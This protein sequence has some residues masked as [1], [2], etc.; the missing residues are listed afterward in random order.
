VDAP[1]S[2]APERKPLPLSEPRRTDAL[3]QRSFI[4]PFAADTARKGTPR[5]EVSP[6]E[7]GPVPVRQGPSPAASTPVIMGAAAPAMAPQTS[8]ATANAENV[9]LAVLNALSS[10]GQTLLVSMLELGEW[11]IQGGELTIKV[12]ASTSL[13][14]MSVGADA[15]RIMVAAASGA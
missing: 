13:I 4:S 12:A 3:P 10:G 7:S 9:R 8:P 6:E 14:E 15:R 5:S 2:S 11:Q 1:R